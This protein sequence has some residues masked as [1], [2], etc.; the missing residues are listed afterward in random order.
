MFFKTQK[1]HLS[2][3][4]GRQAFHDHESNGTSG[5]KL[6]TQVPAPTNENTGC[7]ADV[8]HQGHAIPD[9]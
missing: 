8:G 5:A 7:L 1:E 6:L 2:L 4:E 9:N 3:A